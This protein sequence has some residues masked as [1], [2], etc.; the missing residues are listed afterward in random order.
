MNFHNSNIHSESF[1]VCGVLY[2][3]VGRQKKSYFSK[4]SL[5][6]FEG[7]RNTLVSIGIRC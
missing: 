3:Q 2:T 1:R 4:Q 5:T 6:F 7:M